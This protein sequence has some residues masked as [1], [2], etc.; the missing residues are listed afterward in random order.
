MSAVAVSAVS[1]PPN[2]TSPGFIAY[3]DLLDLQNNA[4]YTE[5]LIQEVISKQN[6]QKSFWKACSDPSPPSCTLEAIALEIFEF[7][8]G[9]K[10]Y[11][12]IEEEDAGKYEGELVIDND[13]KP[14]ASTAGRAKKKKKKKK[15]G[16]KSQKMRKLRIDR[17][18]SG[19][20]W[21]VQVR[22]PGQPKGTSLGF[23]WD[24]NYGEDDGSSG[25]KSGSITDRNRLP[26]LATV[27]YLCNRGAP[28][29]AMPVSKFQAEEQLPAGGLDGEIGIKE[30]YVS[31]PSKGKHMAFK[32]HWLHGVPSELVDEDGAP[33]KA[34]APNEET[35]VAG[36]ETYLRCTFLVNI[37]INTGAPNEIHANQNR[38]PIVNK[39]KYSESAGQPNT[40]YLKGQIKRGAVSEIITDADT[41]VCGFGFGKS[42]SDSFQFWMPLPMPAIHK[43]WDKKSQPRNNFKLIFSGGEDAPCF[44]CRP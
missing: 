34:A 22:G 32:G 42:D 37:W 12:L 5:K 15:K 28:T 41:P 39:C 27:S 17:N 30:G 35:G 20:E 13:S 25:V 14:N 40:S 43:C 18:T 11:V 16:S 4:E 10:D 2:S 1:A 31:F 8:T 3:E 29:V 44:L 38:T 9:G 36:E 7:H 21:W 26:W 19:V 24:E 6:V 33:R 23:H